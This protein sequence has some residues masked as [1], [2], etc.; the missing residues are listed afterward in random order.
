MT[1]CIFCGKPIKSNDIWEIKLTN[2][3][4]KKESNVGQTYCHMDCFVENVYPEY[5]F[6]K[7][8]AKKD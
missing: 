2:F 4:T 5:K 1:C 6:V 3:E 7:L 8:N